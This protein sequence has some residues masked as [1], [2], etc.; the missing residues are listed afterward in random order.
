MLHLAPSSAL[1]VKPI[2]Y[3]KAVEWPQHGGPEHIAQELCTALE[4]SSW[5]IA[6]MRSESESCKP[7]RTH[8]QKDRLGVEG[9]KV[10][11]PQTLKYLPGRRSEK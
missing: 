8:A 7:W 3:A 1:F 2:A 5:R 9:R 11:S 4:A 6:A 10:R